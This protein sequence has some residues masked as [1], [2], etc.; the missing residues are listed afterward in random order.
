MRIDRGQVFHHPSFGLV[1]FVRLD[2]Y[3][4]ECTAQ[5]EGI[6]FPGTYYPKIELMLK[7]G[8]EINDNTISRLG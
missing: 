7:L 1:K 6:E 8:Y 5:L 2:Y 4:G 3:H